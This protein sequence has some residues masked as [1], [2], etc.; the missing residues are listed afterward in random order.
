[1]SASLLA[2]VDFA[3]SLA[4][5]AD[6]GLQLESLRASV[7]FLALCWLI[8]QIYPYHYL[9]VEQGRSPSIDI[10]LGRNLLLLILW[11][12]ILSLPSES[13]PTRETMQKTAAGQGGTS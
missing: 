2:G 10:L 8:T 7:F 5:H 4:Y 12:L 1:M 9:E 11:G 13:E 3:Q 6:R